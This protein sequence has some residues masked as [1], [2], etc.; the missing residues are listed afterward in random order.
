M[1][2]FGHRRRGGYT[3]GTPLYQKKKEQS[4][5][6]KMDDPVVT[7]A[8]AGLCRFHRRGAIEGR[9]DFGYVR[10][11]RDRVVTGYRSQRQGTVVAGPSER[12]IF[13][14]AL[15]QA[16]A[17]ANY[18]G[19]TTNDRYKLSVSI[20]R[21]RIPASSFGD[22]RS[23][24]VATYTLRAPDGQVIFNK[25]VESVGADDTGS[26]LGPARQNRSRTVA[27]AQNVA[28]FVTELQ[29]RLSHYASNGSAPLA[30][31]APAVK[32][33]S[34]PVG[35]H[36]FGQYHALIIGN[37]RY[38]SLPALKTAAMD[39]RRLDHLLRTAYHFK[40]RV[41]LDTNRAGILSALND[42]RRTLQPTDNLLIY[43]A[44]HGWVDNAVDEGYWLP[45]DAES[46]N[47]VNWISNAT[48]TGAIRALPA[49]HVLV[50]ADS[51]YSGKL[52]RG[53]KPTIRTSDYL[54]R[55][56]TRRSRTVLT[57][58]GLEPVLDSGG[59]GGHSVFAAALFDSLE[60]NSGVL[61]TAQIFTDVRRAVTLSADQVPE[62]SD[63]RKAGHD[64]G[65]F[66]FVKKTY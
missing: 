48:I 42:Y 61:D 23:T 36:H 60:R 18:F 22:F 11:H 5:H 58:G 26:I 30:S 16:I 65:D 8:A 50:I 3:A 39:A 40:T 27:V 35:D 4:R 31:M 41:L 47:P 38:R 59:N 33:A 1:R 19:N 29:P 54:V 24:L 17:R 9:G 28:N 32:S 63:I 45:V 52:T 37:N 57:S 20:D 7:A 46:N 53:I 43:Y 14:T 6:E 51:C 10:A 15:T 21:F 66:L 56:A 49:K 13:K 12:T 2:H 55:M 62:Y 44:G 25:A 34:A 64:G